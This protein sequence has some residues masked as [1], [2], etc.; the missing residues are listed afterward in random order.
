[1]AR[2]ANLG[3]LWPALAGLAWSLRSGVVLAHDADLVPPR[4]V[5]TPAPA[6]PGGHAERHDVV[7]PVILVV[8]PDGSVTSVEVEGGVS[9]Q[10]DAAATLL[11][12]PDLFHY[13]LTGEQVAEYTRVATET[14]AGF[15]G[16]DGVGVPGRALLVA[17]TA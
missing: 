11:M 8:S 12:M 10:L 3:Y 1:M 14:I 4:P 5:S 17:G 7:V 16:P 6:W 15:A 2:L 9:P 13:W